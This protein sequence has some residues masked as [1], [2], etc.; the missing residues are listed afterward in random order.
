MPC[1]YGLLRHDL[2]IPHHFIP[3]HYVQFRLRSHRN[4]RVVW[5]NPNAVAYIER[6]ATED[7][8]P[9]VFLAEGGRPRMIHLPGSRRRS[10][11]IVRSGCVHTNQQAGRRAIWQINAFFSVVFLSTAAAY[12]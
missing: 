6:G 7:F 11:H 2:S 12:E 4:A 5:H 9:A 10:I 1:L 8:D 3:F